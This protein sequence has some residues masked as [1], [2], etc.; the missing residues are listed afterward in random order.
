MLLNGSD[1][2]VNCTVA[3]Q[4]EEQL[5]QEEVKDFIREQRLFVKPWIAKTAM[6]FIP[7]SCVVLYMG[8]AQARFSEVWALKHDKYLSMRW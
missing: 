7:L 8:H 5:N 6:H 3:I 4:A 2:S 1:L